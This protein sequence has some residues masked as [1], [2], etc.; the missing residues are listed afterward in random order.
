MPELPEVQTTVDGIQKVAK[1]KAIVDVWTDYNSPF[2]SQNDNI[3][4]PIYF[5]KFRK[6]IIGETIIGSSRRAK[7]VLIHLSNNKTILLHMKMTGHVMYGKY[8]F[9]KNKKKDPW[10]PA[11]NKGA[12][13]DPFNKFLHFVITL[14]DGTN[15]SG[16]LVLS[17]M[18][19]FAKVTLLPTDHLE[20]STDLQHLG[21]EPLDPAFTFNVF[22]ERIYKKKTGKIKTVLMD[23]TLIAGI[24]NIYSDEV[25][26][27]AGIHPEVQ[28]SNIPEKNL[29]TMYKAVQETLRKSIDFG[30]DSMSDYR[31]IYGER[32]EFQEHHEAYRRTHKYCRKPK[33]KGIITRKIVGGRSAHFCDA[34]QKLL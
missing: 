7:N 16:Q 17:D 2:H 33:C 25:L 15:T 4:N 30:G 18:R 13:A 20:A 32:G 14:S 26:W 21:P 29:K 5:K 3:K 34:H 31:N 1:D 6:E 12:L 22:K 9:D 24:G 11:I 27:R 28:V 10:T 23:Q 19:K 8:I